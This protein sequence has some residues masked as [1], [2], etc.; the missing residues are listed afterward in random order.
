M[1][2]HDVP[3]GLLPT[4]TTPFLPSRG[5]DMSSSAVPDMPDGFAYAVTKAMDEHQ[6]RLQFTHLNYSYNVRMSGKRS[7]CHS[8]PAPPG[9]IA[10]AAI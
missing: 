3:I 10:S 5:R 2:F 8:I 4:S 6:D 1:E 7:T 9:I